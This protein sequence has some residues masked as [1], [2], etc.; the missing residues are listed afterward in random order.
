MARELVCKDHQVL[1]KR[2]GEDYLFHQRLE[3]LILR[4]RASTCYNSV[5]DLESKQ[6][7]FNVLTT[8]DFVGQYQRYTASVMYTLTFGMRI[9][10]GQEWAVPAHPSVSSELHQS[11]RG[12]GLDCGC[13]ADIEL[14]S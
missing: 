8:N 2:W 7:F 5:I 14:S 13:S 12:G 3:A 1:F 10:T 6:L 9:V 4:P 11:F